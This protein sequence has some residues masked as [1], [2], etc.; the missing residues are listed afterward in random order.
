MKTYKVLKD[1]PSSDGGYS[2]KKDSIY[3]P[4]QSKQRTKNLIR[5]GYIERIP[6]QPN[7]VWDLKNGDRYYIIEL[8]AH[9]TRVTWTS[10]IFDKSAREIG[11][12]FLTKADA[13]KEL[14][15]RKAKQILLRDTKGFKASKDNDYRHIKVYYAKGCGL[16]T[17]SDIGS[18]DGIQFRN[19]EEAEASIMN[20][21]NEWK[22]YLGVEDE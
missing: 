9:I 14:A 7:T 15:R 3:K 20:H 16:D 4:T 21:P 11:N 17:A 12:I 19:H 5:L 1:F 18:T 10:D 6:E 22:I 2:H 8:G 13:E